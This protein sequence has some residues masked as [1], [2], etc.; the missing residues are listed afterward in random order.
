MGAITV[1]PVGGRRDLRTFVTFPWRIY[2]GDPCWVPPIISQQLKRLDPRRNAFFANARMELFLAESRGKPVGTISALINDRRNTH[3]KIKD[4]YFGFFE[5]VD[6]PTA[7]QALIDAAADWLRSQGMTMLRG[8]IDLDEAEEVGLLIEGHRTR[9]AIML[10]H[11][12]AYYVDLLEGLGFEKWYETSAWMATR[13]DIDERLENL[14]R[15]LFLAAKRAERRS[16]V[17]VR[18]IEMRDWAAEV[19]RL[20]EMWG[21][22]IAVVNQ[23]FAPIEEA[24]LRRMT[25]AMKSIVDPELVALAEIPDDS[26]ADGRRPVGFAVALPDLYQVLGQVNGRLLPFGWARLLIASRQVDALSFKLL[27]VIPEYRLRGI[28][29]LLMLSV[30]DAAWRK[31]YR[32]CDMSVVDEDNVATQ[33]ELKTLGGHIYRTYRVYQRAL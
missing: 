21:S 4:G 7:A 31:G 16:Q 15:K 25:D 33:R 17:R 3:F 13:A 6:D 11:K 24:E 27:G 14:P 5:C 18:P 9:P 28:E 1:R 19:G 20:Y 23:S 12:P 32:T 10:A 29:A 26:R 2:A 8:P 30:I 22:T